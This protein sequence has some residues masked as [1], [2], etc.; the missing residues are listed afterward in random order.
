LGLAEKSQHYLRRPEERQRSDFGADPN[1]W[2]VGCE[3]TSEEKS[4]RNANL[5]KAIWKS[6]LSGSAAWE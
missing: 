6:R 2:F 4:C 1:G 3:Y 5:E